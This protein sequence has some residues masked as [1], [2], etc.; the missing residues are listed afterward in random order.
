MPERLGEALLE[1]GTDDRKLRRGLSQAEKRTRTTIRKLAAVFAGMVTIAAVRGLAR[2]FEQVITKLDMI[3]KQADK[4]GL[5]TEALQEMRFAAERS[6][7]AVTT[8]DMAFQRFTRRAGEAAKGTGEAK[9]ALKELGFT[10]DDLRE[11]SPEELF[12][13]AAAA[14]ADTT[15]AAERLRL[16]FKL[17]DS[18]GVAIVNMVANLA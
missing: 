17:F 9:D 11:K 18:E 16:A 7:V 10:L 13:Q 15:D 8:F 2:S 3:A 6:G 4:L 12:Q 1:L 5:T 14:L